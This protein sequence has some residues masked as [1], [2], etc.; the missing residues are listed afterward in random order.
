VKKI[1]LL[2]SA[3]SLAV[4]FVGCRNIDISGGNG[5]SVMVFGAKGDGV[6]DDTA[7]IQ[8][9]INYTS[10]RG[11][12]KIR[13]PYTPQ[14]YRIAGAAVETVDGKPC[15]GQLYIPPGS[16]NIELEGE[17][18]CQ[19]LYT[20]QVRPPAHGK[21][22]L[23]TTR[24]G[25]MR[26]LN[27][28]IFSDWDA[29]EIRDPVERPYALLATVQGSS[30]AG[31]FSTTQVSITNLEFRVKLHKDRMYPT[32][33]AV[34]LQNA[35]RICVRSSQFCL[36]DNVGDY[37]LK[38]ELQSNPCHTAGLIAS[39][40]QIDH[41]VIDNVAVQGFRYGFVFG[42]HINAAYLYVHNC[43]NGIVFLDRTHLSLIHH[44]VAQHNQKV[45]VAGE[46][47][48]FGMKSHQIYVVINGIDLEAGL[49]S[50]PVVS[51]MTHGLWD[52]E[53]R[54]RGSIKWHVGGPPGFVYFPIEGGKNIKCSK[55]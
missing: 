35:S 43:E 5:V 16:C 51:R 10:K 53:N 33:S 26:A 27:T 55:I 50:V 9:A 8:A 34:N 44:V 4:I 42:E 3:I 41:Q 54:F 45:V 14:G 32:Q 21:Q 37:Y 11:G 23:A 28:Y 13:F 18:P 39:G 52:P 30:G 47:G 48:L 12:G 20:Y 22:N 36:D 29:P 25:T 38:K 31:K 7:A 2:C 49:G 19:L 46:N 40:D 1:Y 6:T 24:F 15:R 17:M